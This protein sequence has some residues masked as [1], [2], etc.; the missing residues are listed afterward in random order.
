MK[1]SYKNDY[2]FPFEKLEVWSKAMFLTKLIYELTSTFPKSEIYGLSSQLQRAVVSIP[3]NIAEGSVRVSGK[4]QS[5]FYEIA[6]GSLMEVLSQVIIAEQLNFIDSN[7][8]I[9]I[10]CIIEEISRML[11]A[12]S[13]KSNERSE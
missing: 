7:Q 8:L 13:R 12:L 2:K 10:R 5:R 6:F 1:S 9:E 3:S 4:E 11:N